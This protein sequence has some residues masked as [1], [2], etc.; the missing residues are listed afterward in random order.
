MARNKRILFSLCVAVLATLFTLSASAWQHGISS[1]YGG[2]K[3][4]N[5]NYGAYG[6]FLNGKLYQL[7]RIDKTM[8]LTL[9]VS[10][11]HWRAGTAQNKNLTTLALSG[12]FR[13]YFAPPEDHQWRPYLQTTAGLAYLSSKMFGEQAQGSHA[14]LQITLGAGMEVALPHSDKS[15][16]LNWRLVH[17][18]NA[19][20]FKP[21]QSLN[22]LYVFSL[23]YLF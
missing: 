7:K 10:A 17:F 23:G 9:D 2:S 6:F 1:G 22:L 12:A 16:D 3:E 14:A 8:L 4:I 19:G 5:K 18:S 15:L 21:N 13:A 20:L 11:A